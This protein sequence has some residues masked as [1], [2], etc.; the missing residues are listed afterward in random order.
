MTKSDDRI[1][2]PWGPVVARGLNQWQANDYV[3]PF[4][5]PNGHVLRATDDGWVCDG[6]D[7]TQDWAW[8]FMAAVGL[9]P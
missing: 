1:F 5:C 3:H 8:A 2:A 6:C 7:Y 4:T 9:I